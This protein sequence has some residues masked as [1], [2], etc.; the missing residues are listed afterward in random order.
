[1]SSQ[2]DRAIFLPF[3]E[4]FGAQQHRDRERSI[5]CQLPPP[6]FE[7]TEFYTGA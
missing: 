3:F 2:E 5:L 7:L 6:F 1:M 4:E